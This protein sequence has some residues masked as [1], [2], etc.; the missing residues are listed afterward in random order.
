[1]DKSPPGIFLTNYLNNPTKK[2]LEM[3]CSS[4]EE[5]VYIYFTIVKVESK[6]I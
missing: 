4:V 2:K 1:M 6:K 3:V 5:L